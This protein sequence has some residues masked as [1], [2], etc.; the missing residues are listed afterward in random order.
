MAFSQR[1]LQRL[2]LGDI[3]KGEC[4]THLYH[5]CVCSN[6]SEYIGAFDNSDYYT[7][8]S[9][10]WVIVTISFI[11]ICIPLSKKYPKSKI[12]NRFIYPLIVAGLSNSLTVGFVSQILFTNLKIDTPDADVQ[13][14]AIDFFGVSEINRTN[15]VVH[16]IPIFVCIL[17]L[18]FIKFITIPKTN[19]RKSFGTFFRLLL[20]SIFFLMFVFILWMIIPIDVSKS[21]GVI[22]TVWGFE[23]L[24]YT[25]SLPPVYIYFVFPL[26]ALFSMCLIAYSIIY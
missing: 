1:V 14:E 10:V 9:F 26:I 19:N 25:Y 6:R 5:S 21:S 18:F 11:L 24:S 2:T 22:E 8:W 16:I 15:F 13:P 23:K 3:E 12:L 17:G 4:D 20:T 7:Y